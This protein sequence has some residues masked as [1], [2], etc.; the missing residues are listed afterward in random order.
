MSE[1]KPM[2]EPGAEA[3]LES[4]KEIAAYLKRDV[5]TAKRWEANEGLPIRRH[6]H[7]SRASVY[8]YP[9]ELDAWVASRQPQA[10]PIVVAPRVR[11]QSMAGLATGLLIAV[12]SAGGR[13]IS[14]EAA[15]STPNPPITLRKV[16]AAGNSDATGAVSPDGRYLSYAN[17]APGDL[18]LRDL[19]TGTNRDLTHEGSWGT[20]RF[21]Y[22]SIWSPDGKQVGYRWTNGDH[23]EV[24]VIGLDATAPRVLYVHPEKGNFG[25]RPMA[26]SADGKFIAGH[27]S[28]ADA[29]N[30]IVLLSTDTGAVRALKSTEWRYPTAMSFSP[31]GRW[32]AYDAQTAETAPQRDVFLLAI[33]GSR[34]VTL[35]NHPSHDY[36]PV[37]TRDGQVLFVSDRSGSNGLWT[38]AAG[39]DD[40]QSSPRLLKADVGAMSPMGLT[41]DGKLYL[42][43]ASGQNAGDVFSVAIDR[44]VGRVVGAPALAVRTFEGNN[45]TPAFSPDGT[46]MAFL[47]R[48][49]PVG[50]ASWSLV[51]QSRQTGSE[52]VLKTDLSAIE[53]PRASSLRW[54]PDG[55]FILSAGVD[56]RG[57]RGLYRLDAESGTSRLVVQHAFPVET[58]PCWAPDGE[59]IYLIRLD[60]DQDRKSLIEYNLRTETERVLHQ[61]GWLTSLAISPDGTQLA[62]IQGDTDNGRRVLA[63]RVISLKDH[64]VRTLLRRPPEILTPNVGITWEEDGRSL[65]F[66][67]R[68]AALLPNQ[69]AGGV[70][71]GVWRLPLSGGE[72]VALGVEAEG[73]RNLV[74]VPGGRELAFTSGRPAR[75][76]V[77]V[78]EDF[79]PPQKTGR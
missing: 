63:L 79:L 34:E 7:Q 6:M 55:R 29:T 75:A 44:S 8:A 56:T 59:T 38:V 74:I 30:Q 51:I 70:A 45:T 13:P 73:L 49:G 23:S 67:Q 11:W 25:I 3:P 28:R 17:W 1:L 41:H 24:R 62:F 37:F 31:D 20:N 50:G 54:S 35:V 48:R 76:E 42:G 10:E 18:G 46:R 19:T 12:N 71:V 27:L 53:N 36:G 26:W 9:S 21:A 5:R 58:Y 78:I 72:P 4:W 66:T 16:W 47:S 43:Y 39:A 64:Q 32:L 60:A 61:A 68:V 77:W 15:Q 57:R 2:G 69:L 14:T 40:V 52:R 65:L 33:D 22:Y